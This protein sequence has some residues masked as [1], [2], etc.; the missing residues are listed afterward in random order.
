[1]AE[2]WLYIY[3]NKELNSIYIGIAD[4]MSRV[5]QTHNQA[6]EQLRDAAGSVI[7]QTVKPFSSRGDARKAEA[8]AIYVATIAGTTV[9]G[10]DD[11][12]AAFT[13]TNI[14]GVQSTTELGPAI[15]AKPG[16]IQWSTLTGTVIVSI[17]ADELE[18]RPAP[19]G[20]H[21]GAFFSER[22]RQYWQS[23]AKKRP[24]ITRLLALLKGSGNIIL[25]DWDVTPESEWSRAPAHPD[26]VAVPLVDAEQDDP[27]GVKGMRLDG[28]RSNVGVGYS[29]D[30]K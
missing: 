13:S 12:G 17:D 26:R 21:G 16:A 7:L 19:F 8:I 25:G 22:A 24:R 11:K 10:E 9:L 27:R 20:A 1:M 2:C 4:S 5:F 30:L 29:S 14:S 3:E 15:F 23:T 6:A 28:H 18:G